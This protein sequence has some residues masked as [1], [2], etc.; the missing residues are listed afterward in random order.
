[1]I[2]QAHRTFVLSLN[3]ELEIAM[4]LG[5]IAEMYV[6]GERPERMFRNVAVLGY[7][8]TQERFNEI[9]DLGLDAGVWVST[10]ASFTKGGKSRS[11]FILGK[12]KA[13]SCLRIA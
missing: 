3:N 10:I 2:T 12:H 11:V 4:V 9:V 7:G 6:N 13:V 8:V 5:M 1:M